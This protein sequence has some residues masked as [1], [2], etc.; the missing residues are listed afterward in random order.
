MC[1]GSCMASAQDIISTIEACEVLGGID[2][3]TL[4]RWVEA[5]KVTPMH[6]MPG[7]T[8][9]WLFTRAEIERVAAEQLKA[10]S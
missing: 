1:N 9:A 7:V 4:T 10:A 2:R 6:K 5:G 3:S 8:G